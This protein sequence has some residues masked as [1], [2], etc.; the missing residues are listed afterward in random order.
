MKF[1]NK[2][3]VVM[4]GR[5]NGRTDKPNAICPF[6]FSKVGGIIQNLSVCL[7][8]TLHLIC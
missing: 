2:I 5:T 6:N 3:N 7:S 4:D 8:L 1:Q